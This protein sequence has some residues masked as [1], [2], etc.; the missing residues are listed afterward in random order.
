MEFIACY[1]HNDYFNELSTSNFRFIA[2]LPVTMSKRHA[3]P[4]DQDLPPSYED[5]VASKA[6]PLPPDTRTVVTRVIR[7][8]VPQLGPRPATIQCPGCQATI[9]TRTAS[10]PGLLAVS[11]S[12]I[13]C[14]TGLWPCFCLPFCV[15]SLQTVKHYCP[16]CNIMVGKYKEM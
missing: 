6:G 1:R 13:L 9:T 2:S 12:A 3:R 8:E 11:L 16:S 4:M 10:K 7:V 14:I 5:T 15:D